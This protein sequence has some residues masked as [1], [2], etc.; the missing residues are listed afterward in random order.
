MI[1]SA[2]RATDIP[3]CLPA[4]FRERWR[5]G[6]VERVNPFSGKPALVS[7]ARTRVL[8][9]WTKNPAPFFPVLDE[10]DASGVHYYFQFTLNDYAAEGLEPGLPSPGERVE[11]FRRLAGRLGPDRVVWRFDPLILAHGL[12]VGSL[13]RKVDGL[14]ARLSGSTRKLVISFADVT[15]YPAVRARV[16]DP[17]IGWREFTGAEREDLAGALAATARREGLEI[18]ACAEPF[19]LDRFGV[20]P[21]RCIDDVL[22]ARLFPGD[23]A[24]MRFLGRPVGGGDPAPDPR[25]K[26]R[27]QRK[28][29]GCIVSRDIGSYGTCRLGCV[30]CYARRSSGPLSPEPMEGTF[31]AETGLTQGPCR[32]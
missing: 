17:G 16:G 1:V 22:L 23:E 6:F 13:A 2:S 20:P 26:D 9:F 5:A 4:W 30:Y 27:G 14:A 3:A 28:A 7:F 18:G 32:S 31:S 8:V 19:P 25:L 15:N 29:C 12:T 10:L 21:N 11:T 24:L